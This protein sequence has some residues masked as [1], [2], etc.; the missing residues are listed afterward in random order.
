MDEP[1]AP[2]QPAA[3]VLGRRYSENVPDGLVEPVGAKR[4]DALE[5]APVLVHAVQLGAVHMLGGGTFLDCLLEKAAVLADA[6]SK[7]SSALGRVRDRVGLYLLIREL[8]SE[9]V[10]GHSCSRQGVVSESGFVGFTDGQDGCG[11]DGV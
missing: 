9:I 11:E 8:M 1:D 3:V 6:C 7:R 4:I 5:V 2:E 10:S